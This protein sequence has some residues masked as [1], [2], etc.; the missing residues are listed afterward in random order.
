MT[1]F[2]V[3]VKINVSNLEWGYTL[4]LFNVASIESSTFS[5]I[6]GYNKEQDLQNLLSTFHR[7]A[8]D[9]FVFFDCVISSPTFEEA[10]LITSLVPDMNKIDIKGI[11]IVLN[12]F[13]GDISPENR[14]KIAISIDFVLNEI[15]KSSKVNV[16]TLKNYFVKLIKAYDSTFLKVVS[17]LDYTRV[18][19]LYSGKLTKYASA[20][21]LSLYKVGIKIV[22]FSTQDYSVPSSIP[23][24]SFEGPLQDFTK[25]NTFYSGVS[26]QIILPEKSRINRNNW[27]VLNKPNLSDNLTV[28]YKSDRI[29]PKEF[30]TVTVGYKGV[31]ESKEIYQQ[32]LSNF[33]YAHNNNIL[34]VNNK[35]SNPNYDEVFIASKVSIDNLQEF[36]AFIGKYRALKEAHCENSLYQKFTNITAELSKSQKTIYFAWLLRICDKFFATDKLSAIPIICLFGTLD[37]KTI[38]FIE[39]LK[40]LPVD[41]LHFS[42]NYK[43]EISAIS[44]YI[45]VG[46][47][48]REIIAY[49]EQE[50][51]TVETIAYNAEKQIQEILYKDSNDFFKYKQ[52][53]K[54]NH[55]RLKTT[56]DEANILWREPYKYRTGFEVNNGIVTAPTIFLKVMGTL[57]DKDEYLRDIKN[58]LKD[59]TIL[60]QKRNLDVSDTFTNIQSSLTGTNYTSEQDVAAPFLKQLWF[61]GE[62]DKER[63]LQSN[64]WQYGRFSE[65]TRITIIA[66]MEEVLKSNFLKSVG[67][68]NVGN[69]LYAMLNIDMHIMN[70]VHQND[71]TGDVPKIV[72]F[73]PNGE[74]LSLEE[75]SQIMLLYALGFDIMVY[76]PTGYVT[77]ENYIPR[78]YY[79][80]VTIGKYNFE[81]GDIDIELY[82]SVPKQKGFFSWFS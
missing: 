82:N 16:T 49:P 23:I 17:S 18:R 19:L 32:L 35:F 47:S 12:K 5:L 70:L 75:C 33:K 44:P 3:F 71:F 61:G 77:I 55:I 54:Y 46:E 1:S 79:D 29:L 50:T 69:I 73:S 34:I 4:M 67:V 24:L 59:G 45:V 30:K 13:F 8:E 21:L 64:Y 43:D 27:A 62:L 65:E 36:T 57:E 15:K 22:L 42:P 37:K 26:A 51:K 53:R 48:S 58:K 2:E 40:E 52:Y 41:I 28:L 80:D 76:S 66:K 63:L 39:I 78:Q 60:I 74:P 38:T 7:N 9:T 14:K 68:K 25:L 56:Y 81:L 31:F 10:N 72:V 6:K 11:E 20:I